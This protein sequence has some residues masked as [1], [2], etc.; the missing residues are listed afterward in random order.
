MDVERRKRWLVIGAIVCVGLWLA[1]T[2]VL[3]PLTELWKERSARIV[4][5]EG[6]IGKS[7][8]LL[9]REAFLKSRWK[10]MKDQALPSRGSDAEQAVFQEVS[11]WTSDIN[12]S[13]TSL[14]PRWTAMPGTLV[15]TR[16]DQE[17]Q[18]LDIQLEAIGNME[19]IVKFVFALESSR[20]PLR[21]E[22]IEVSLPN[23]NAGRLNLSLR[24]TGLVLTEETP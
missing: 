2:F 4:E 12:L 23:N 9:D 6:E 1:D 19:G 7:G 3:T 20:L 5:L 22:D 11:Q 8:G 10:D 15:K 18:M 21:V 13:V 14:K 24:F 16:S 17:K